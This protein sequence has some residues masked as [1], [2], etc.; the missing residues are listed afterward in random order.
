MAD[1]KGIEKSLNEVFAGKSAPKLPEGGKKFLVEY[2]PYFVLVGAVLSLL[3]AWSMWSWA[4][5]VSRIADWANQINQVYG[6]GTTIAT[7]RLT[8]FVWLALAFMVVNTVLYFMAFAPLKDK[9]KR[10]WNLVFYAALLSVAYSVVLLFIDNQGF[11]SFLFGLLGSAIG[12]WLLFQI[13]PAYKT[14]AAPDKPA[15]KS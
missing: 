3:G 5:A 10:G 15:A 11:G 6:T 2:G 13:R 1:V 14:V 8:V 7:N 12:F 4:H 9:L